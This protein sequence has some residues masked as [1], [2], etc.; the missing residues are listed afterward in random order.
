MH[1]FKSGEIVVKKWDAASEDIDWAYAPTEDEKDTFRSNLKELDT[2]LAP[3]P[4]DKY[5]QWF[6]L[7]QFIR[8]DLVERVQPE[9]GRCFVALRFTQ[10]RLASPFRPL[11]VASVARD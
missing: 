7:T 1:D 6:S 10:S 2:R 8:V 4:Y 5:K 11:V 3:Y 9:S